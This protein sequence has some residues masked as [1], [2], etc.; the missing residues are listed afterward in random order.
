MTFEEVWEELGVVPEC[1]DEW[2]PIIIECHR[3]LKEIDP[4]YRASQIKE[5]W[6]GL[7]FYFDMTELPTESDVGCDEKLYDKMSKVVEWA[8][9][10]VSKLNNK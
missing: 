3:K 1:P 10:E 4:G 9:E 2:Y 5:K 8:E 6:G 7:R